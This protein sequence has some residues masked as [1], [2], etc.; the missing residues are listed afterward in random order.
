MKT[1]YIPKGTKVHPFIWKASTN[2]LAWESIKCKSPY[3]TKTIV[4]WVVTEDFLL[5][6]DTDNPFYYFRLSEPDAHEAWTAFSVLK[7]DVQVSI[8]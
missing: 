3:D 5:P 7:E 8:A 1:Y 2:S 6:A 4:N